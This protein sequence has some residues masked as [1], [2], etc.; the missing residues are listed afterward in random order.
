MQAAVPGQIL[1]SEGTVRQVE[2]RFVWEKL[3]PITVKGKAEPLSVYAVSQ[4]GAEPT[5]RLQEPQYALPM[6]GREAE[7]AMIQQKMAQVKAGRGQI[8]TISGEAGIGKSRLVA[9]IIRLAG[10]QQFLGFGGECQ[11]YG[12]GT[13]YLV[14]QR[15]WQDFLS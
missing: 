11:S 15:I 13:S 1:V 5:I 9:Q 14:W 6:V 3:P 8:V 7:Q 10:E 4:R 2:D 12:T